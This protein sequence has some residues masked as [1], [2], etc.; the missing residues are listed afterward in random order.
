M[1]LFTGRPVND[2]SPLQ[3][4]ALEELNLTR[5]ERRETRSVPELPVRTS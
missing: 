5:P 3:G 2:L 1:N 4:M